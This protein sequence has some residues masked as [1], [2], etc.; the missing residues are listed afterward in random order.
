MLRREVLPAFIEE[1]RPYPEEGL[2]EISG[3]EWNPA[4]GESVFSHDGRGERI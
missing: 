2:V 1:I 4:A 3:Y